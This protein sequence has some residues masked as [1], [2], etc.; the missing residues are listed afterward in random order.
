MS[1]SA[2]IS[3]SLKYKDSIISCSSEHWPPSKISYFNSVPLAMSA[4]LIPIE[5]SY[6]SGTASVT[7]TGFSVAESA[8]GSTYSY[9]YALVLKRR[10]FTGTTNIKTEWV[11]VGTPQFV[12]AETSAEIDI[13]NYNTVT[14]PSVVGTDLGMYFSKEMCCFSLYRTK[15]GGT[16]YYKLGDFA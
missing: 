12:T 6:S 13:T 7:N 14:F 9:E 3:S 10:Y 2:N 5:Y 16:S 4:G 8:S 15:A 11:D 1:T